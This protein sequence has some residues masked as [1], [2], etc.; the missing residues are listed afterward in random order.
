MTHLILMMIREV[1]HDFKFKEYILPN[2]IINSVSMHKI[3]E[4]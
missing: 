4:I 3:I 2:D 1:Y